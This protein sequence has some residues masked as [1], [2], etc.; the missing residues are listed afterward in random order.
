M[1]ERENWKKEK[2]GKEGKGREGMEGK[3]RLEDTG[4]GEGGG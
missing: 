2:K 1:E 3:V 4:S